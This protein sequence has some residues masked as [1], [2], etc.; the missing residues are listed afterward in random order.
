MPKTEITYP[1]WVQKY[2]ERGTTVK[3]KG[4]SYYLYKRTSKRVPGKKYPQPVDTYIGIIT[5]KGV[6]KTQKKK[7]TLTDIE[8]REYGF[9]KALLEICP[10]GWKDAVGNEWEDVLKLIVFRKSHLTYFADDYEFKDPSDFHCSFGAQTGMLE[11]RIYR[12]YKIK[13]E[14][15]EILKDIYLVH[16]GKEE[17]VSHISEQQQI[18]LKCI[19]VK[20]K[21]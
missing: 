18:L 1:E 5:P 8:V 21:S 12:E 20:L 3:K 4:N 16:I 7:V 14:E 13:I 9:S 2:R 17:A 19:N 11:K 6:E 10:Q 15:M